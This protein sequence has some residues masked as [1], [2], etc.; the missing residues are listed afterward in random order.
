M[1]QRV[2]LPEAAH[3]VTDRPGA[4]AHAG[5]AAEEAQEPR[6]DARNGTGPIVAAGTDIEERTAAV[7]AVARHGQFEWRGKRPER[8]L[9][10]PAVFL[11]IPFRFGRQSV[12]DRTRIV[13]TVLSLPQIVILRAAPVVWVV[14]NKNEAPVARLI[15]AA[16]GGGGW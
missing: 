10:A 15:G 12:A 3:R 7:A 13:D 4:A 8:I 6:A 9:A 5:I 2:L 16:Q 1:N 14:W 11:G